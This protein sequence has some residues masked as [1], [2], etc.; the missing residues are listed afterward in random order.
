MKECNEVGH[1]VWLCVGNE[2]HAGIW[3]IGLAVLGLNVSLGM[4]ICT[5][6]PHLK[7]IFLS[8]T[9]IMCGIP[10]LNVLKTVSNIFWEML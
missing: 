3:G 1:N 6:V 7:S 9:V 8:S 5:M 10:W 4:H 2:I